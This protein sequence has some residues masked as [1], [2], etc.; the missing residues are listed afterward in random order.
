MRKKEKT[1]DQE[2]LREVVTEPLREV[3]T[4]NIFKP[5]SSFLPTLLTPFLNFIFWGIVN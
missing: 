2:P 4:L 3:V 1:V 5:E